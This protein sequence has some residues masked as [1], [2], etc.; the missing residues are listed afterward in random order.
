MEYAY[1][2]IMFAFSAGLLI[3]AGILAALK[4]PLLIPRHH[5]TKGRNSKAYVLRIAKITAV[6]ASAPLLSAVT[7]L[8][9]NMETTLLPALLVLII[10]F[11]I[12]IY[13]GVKR[14]K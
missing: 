10:G 3:Y 6:C 8:I 12:C 5:A 1:S 14:I 13:L 9:W 7:G 11:V 4:D 2:I